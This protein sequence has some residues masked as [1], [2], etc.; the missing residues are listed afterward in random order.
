MAKNDLPPVEELVTFGPTKLQNLKSN[1]RNVFW[2]DVLSSWAEFLRVYAPDNLE[3]LTDKLWYSDHTRFKKTIVNE[4]NNKGFRFISDLF[5]KD[6]GLLLDR[7]TIK[8]KCG[9]SMTFLCYSSLIRSIPIDIRNSCWKNIK[10]PVIPYKVALLSRKSDTSRIAYNKF[11]FALFVKHLSESDSLERKWVRDAG[12]MVKGTM[13]D[14]R[15][16]TKNI[17]LQTFHYRIVNRIISTNTFLFRIGLSENPSCSFCKSSNETLIHVLWDC[18][19]TQRYIEELKSHLSSTYNLRLNIDLPMWVF[20]TFANV[21]RITV[22]IITL[23][24]LVIFKARNAAS[25]PSIRSFHNL[26]KWEAEKESCAAKRRSTFN[27]FLEKW[28]N[29]ANILRV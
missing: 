20:P 19:H 6:T 25:T 16:S 13:F 15:N 27:S 4:W 22:L 8:E 23:G 5:C 1:V 18:R 7:E 26:L 9:L 17:Y 29:V 24:K 2:K 12:T 14:I 28:E 21:N 11:I 10:Y 3:V